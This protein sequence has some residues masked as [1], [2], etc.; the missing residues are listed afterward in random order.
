M[1]LGATTLLTAFLAG[2]PLDAL[3]GQAN[4]SRDP[5]EYLKATWYAL[6]QLDPGGVI[7]DAPRICVDSHG[8]STGLADPRDLSSLAERDTTTVPFLA[9]VGQYVVDAADCWATPSD[10]AYPTLYVL[11]SITRRG[12]G[13]RD[14]VAV[15]LFQL[16][17]ARPCAATVT[18]RC[19][20]PA[21]GATTIYVTGKVTK[22]ASGW[23]PIPLRQTN[24]GS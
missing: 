8:L 20:A 13:S 2:A 6:F 7:T 12:T 14:S 23:P 22:T 4:P 3:H 19:A 21:P 15:A 18:P 5:V 1:R 24:P 17:R 11:G 10:T 9:S 16:F